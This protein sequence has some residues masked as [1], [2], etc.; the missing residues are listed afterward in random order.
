MPDNFE[1]SHSNEL[2]LD[3]ELVPVSLSD[4]WG[5]LDYRQ[6][7]S[8]HLF[9]QRPFLDMAF[10]FNDISES[11]IESILLSMDNAPR[12]L[13]EP[14]SCSVNAEPEDMSVCDDTLSDMYVSLPVQRIFNAQLTTET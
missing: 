8:T 9:A 14:V 1:S 4:V 2:I 12:P 3:E 10:P 7:P 6:L 5:D 13:T 11:T